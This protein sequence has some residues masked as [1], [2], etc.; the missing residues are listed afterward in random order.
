M[1]EE[2][3][4]PDEVLAEA[5]MGLYVSFCG[6]DDGEH[7]IRIIVASRQED[8][9]YRMAELMRKKYEFHPK[10]SLTNIVEA[11]IYSRKLHAVI[12]K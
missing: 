10:A 8:A 6:T 1:A 4:F 12:M 11:G 9:D 7:N 3:K 2:K 5:K